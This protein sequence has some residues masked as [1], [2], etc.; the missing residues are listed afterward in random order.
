[1]IDNISDMMDMGIES[2][3]VE[4][5]M[6]SMYYIATVVNTYKNS[7]KEEYRDFFYNK[8]IRLLLCA[9]SGHQ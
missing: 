6:K 8:G 5:R 4:G 3:K 7:F 2:Y 1:M 9:F